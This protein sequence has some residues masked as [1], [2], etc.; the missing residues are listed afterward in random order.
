[1]E[2]LFEVLMRTGLSLTNASILADMIKSLYQSHV[3]TVFVNVPDL[4]KQLVTHST[5]NP[6]LGGALFEFATQP[7]SHGQLVFYLCSLMCMHPDAKKQICRR[8]EQELRKVQ[9]A[10][11]DN[12][13]YAL[14]GA[15]GGVCVE[16]ESY[17]MQLIIAFLV[18]YP[19][20]S[21]SVH[22]S[23][24]TMYCTAECIGMQQCPF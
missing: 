18:H 23:L 5:I 14:L 22:F 24:C 19:Q 9:K 21:A 17:D 7:A 2:K 15:L 8:L 13:L 1:M 3:S 4:V 16:V 10:L 20:H 12:S 6:E 11:H